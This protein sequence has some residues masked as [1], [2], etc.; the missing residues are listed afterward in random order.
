MAIKETLDQISKKIVLANYLDKKQTVPCQAGRKLVVIYENGDVYPCE[1]T[2]Q[3]FGNL[4]EVDYDIKKLLFSETGKTI[5]RRIAD[6]SCYCTWEN[7]INA[8]ILFNPRSYPKIMYNWARSFV[9][10]RD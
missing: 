5:K 2:D 8:S 9:L 3:K 6:N 1:L 4:K 7:I 10:K